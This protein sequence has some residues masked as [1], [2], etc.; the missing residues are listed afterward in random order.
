[1]YINVLLI[2]SLYR[3]NLRTYTD[4]YK[5]DTQTEI[6]ILASNVGSPALYHWTRASTTLFLGLFGI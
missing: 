6:Q 1:M 2:K 4:T 3:F 5:S